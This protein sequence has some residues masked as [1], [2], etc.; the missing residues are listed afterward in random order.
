MVNESLNMGCGPSAPLIGSG[1][2]RGTSSPRAGRMIDCPGAAGSGEASS[3][4][5]GAQKVVAHV[6]VERHQTTARA[7]EAQGRPAPRPARRGSGQP[8]T[9]RHLCASRQSQASFHQLSVADGPSMKMREASPPLKIGA[10][11]WAVSTWHWA[12]LEAAIERWETIK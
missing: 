11:I 4:P 2:A 3:R 6:L 10:A 9:V 7:T 1:D 12:L 5:D 8:S